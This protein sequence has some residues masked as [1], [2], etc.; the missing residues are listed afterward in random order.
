MGYRSGKRTHHLPLSYTFN[1]FK[2]VCNIT[3]IIMYVCL[4]LLQKKWFLK[5]HKNFITILELKWNYNLDKQGIHKQ[6]M[7]PC[8]LSSEITEIVTLVST[9]QTSGSVWL[10][11][12]SSD[13]VSHASNFAIVAE[14]MH[15]TYMSAQIG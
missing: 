15:F 11:D 4:L 3:L 9:C 1:V 10:W 13:L 7:H 5:D 8:G 14:M 6:D 12:K 2:L